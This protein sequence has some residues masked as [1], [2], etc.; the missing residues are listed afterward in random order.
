MEERHRTGGGCRVLAG[1]LEAERLG[2][3]WTFGREHLQA[4]ELRA[5]AMGHRSAAA[6]RGQQKDRGKSRRTGLLQKSAGRQ[7]AI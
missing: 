5:D 4:D 2:Q 1:L 7:S 3:V 6:V